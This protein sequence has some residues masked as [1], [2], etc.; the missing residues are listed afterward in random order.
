MKHPA[1]LQ[2]VSQ[3]VRHYRNLKGLSQQQLAD[4]AGLSRRMVAGVE[5][6]QDN[7]SLAKLSL[8]AD[9]L[10]VD[11]AQMIA[12]PEQHG[13]AVVNALAWQ[14][15]QAQS[16]AILLASVSASKK[17]ELWTWTLAPNEQYCAEPDPEG[18]R[19][20]LYVIE[21]ELTLDLA[22]EVKV[23]HAGESI[24]YA[25]TIDYRYIN[26]ASVPLKFI[27]NAIY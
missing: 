25:S 2:Y 23:L 3:N 11:F 9:V 12:A 13:Q 27:R 16:E 19:E 15:T 6:G 7:I 26:H 18:Y 17:V 21:G 1:V 14:G 10:E 22:G 20:M 24:V 4:L 5:T 8:I